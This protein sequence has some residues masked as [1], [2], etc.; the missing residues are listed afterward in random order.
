MGAFYG[1][2][3]SDQ[4]MQ[5]K[6]YGTQ[7]WL[8]G[9]H[10]QGTID[11]HSKLNGNLASICTFSLTHLHTHS[12]SACS[13]IFMDESYILVPPP[14][15]EHQ[16]VVISEM[17]CCNDCLPWKPEHARGSSQH[18]ES[19]TWRF[20]LYTATL[21]VI[22]RA[23]VL[24]VMKKLAEKWG[25]SSGQIRCTL[26]RGGLSVPHLPCCAAFIDHFIEV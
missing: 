13:V 3:M 2:L 10:P 5:W 11:I 25:T 17:S 21:A 24:Y 9:Y 19:Q 6:Q 1:Y 8:W 20:D 12:L 16:L 23:K 4:I 18:I 26:S 15:G 7:V 14:V 22:S